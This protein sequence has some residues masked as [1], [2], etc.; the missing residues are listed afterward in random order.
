MR[1]LPWFDAAAVSLSGL[2]LAHCIALPVAAALLPS[3]ASWTQAP[4]LHWAFVALALPTT[5]AAL[6]RTWRARTLSPAVAAAA[7]A[8]LALLA[9]GASEAFGEALEVPVTVAGSVVLASA[10][11]ANW[12]AHRH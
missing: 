5:A 2:C 3:L 7:I 4:W 8:G 10:H 11:I 12:R 9:L 6:L 1:T